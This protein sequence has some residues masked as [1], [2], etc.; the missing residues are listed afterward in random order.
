MICCCKFD[1][2]FPKIALVQLLKVEKVGSVLDNLKV[3]PKT[4]LYFTAIKHRNYLAFYKIVI[5]FKLS[6]TPKRLQGQGFI[7]PRGPSPL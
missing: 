1:F 4:R 2:D 5:A 3:R 7:D 6:N